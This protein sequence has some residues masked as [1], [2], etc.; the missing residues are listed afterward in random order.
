MSDDA[1]VVE[2]VPYDPAWPARFKIEQRLLSEA[3]PAALSVEHFGSTSV[4]GLAAKPII[5]ILVV[6]PEVGAVAADVRPLE[7]LGYVYRPLAFPDDNEHLFFAKDTAGKRS[8][9]LHVFG[10][11]S[12]VPQ[13][14]RVFRAYL[15]ATPD[16]ALRY[17]AAKRRAAEL[18]PHSRAQ[19][20]AAKEEVFAQLSAEARLWS[21]SGGASQS[22]RTSPV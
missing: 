3:L 20:G 14:N 19:Y 9:H 10:V 4:P 6:V 13:A 12:L 2:V 1:P 15:A 8:H 11:M 16:A 17:E 22:F 5:D 18:H 7:Q 21:L